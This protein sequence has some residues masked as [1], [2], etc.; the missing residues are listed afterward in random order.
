MLGSESFGIGIFK[1]SALSTYAISNSNNL[2]NVCSHF[3]VFLI[4]TY[5]VKS[6]CC[7]IFSGPTSLKNIIKHLPVIVLTILFKLISPIFMNLWL[8]I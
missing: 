2:N 3:F 8:K 5:C 6:K 7:Y 1:L 4:K